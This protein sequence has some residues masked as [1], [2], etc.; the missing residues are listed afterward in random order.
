MRPALAG[1]LL[2]LAMSA[3]ALA[4]DDADSPGTA[5]ANHDSFEDGA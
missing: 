3:P 4:Q 5:W 1:P 2:A